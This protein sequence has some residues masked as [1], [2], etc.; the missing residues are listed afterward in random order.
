MQNN[1]TSNCHM[2]QVT[3]TS[4]KLGQFRST[5][6]RKNREHITK[7]CNKVIKKINPKDVTAYEKCF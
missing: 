3:A 1:G 2:A 4:F 5:R 7:K 6:Q